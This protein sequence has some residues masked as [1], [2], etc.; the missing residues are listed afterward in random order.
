MSPSVASAI[1]PHQVYPFKAVPLRGARWKEA[2]TVEGDRRVL[3]RKIV[4][5]GRPGAIFARRPYNPEY[6]EPH[7][8]IE[9]VRASERLRP[10]PRVANAPSFG[11]KKRRAHGR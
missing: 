5:H 10:T 11:K 9:G 2:Y 1:T 8:Y 3:S 4:R 7:A 6:A